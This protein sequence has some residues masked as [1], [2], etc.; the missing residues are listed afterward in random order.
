MT[1]PD[2]TGPTK[3]IVVLAAYNRAARLDSLPAQTFRDCELILS[4]DCSTEATG[5]VAA[6]QAVRDARIRCCRNPTN[7]RM[8]GNRNAVIGEARGEDIAIAH[9]SDIYRANLFECCYSALD[10]HPEAA[11]V[12]NAYASRDSDRIDPHP[13]PERMDGR[14]FL[15]EI[16]VPNWAACLL[17]EQAR[18]RRSAL[19]VAGLFD[20][21]CSIQ[22]RVAVR[23]RLAFRWD[24]AY[25]DEPLSHVAPWESDPLPNPQYRWEKAN[26]RVKRRAWQPVHGPTGGGR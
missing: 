22:A 2:P 5:D 1:A 15:S 9:G 7:P 21:R 3:V 17:F 14:R 23:S 10:R 8:P 20:L 25:V 24:V 13:I 16:F 4:D 6:E 11:F 26:V 12:F 18:V 19:D